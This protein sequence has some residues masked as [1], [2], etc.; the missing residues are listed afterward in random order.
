MDCLYFYFRR[1]EASEK[2]HRAVGDCVIGSSV[3]AARY[4]Q[5]WSRR[6]G[7]PLVFVR[8]VL[9]QPQH[10]LRVI[11]LY[12]RGVGVL[13]S[14]HVREANESLGEPLYVHLAWQLV[15]CST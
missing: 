1:E 13:P 3:G 2:A 8:L 4:L 15:N 5:L 10:S 9:C 14:R 6:I 7:R 12:P 11:R